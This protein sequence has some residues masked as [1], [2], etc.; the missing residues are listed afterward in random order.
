M[1]QVRREENGEANG[2]ATVS[3]AFFV[4]QKMTRDLLG[5]SGQTTMCIFLSEISSNFCIIYISAYIHIYIYIHTHMLRNIN[6][7]VMFLDA[8][9]NPVLYSSGDC[10]FRRSPFSIIS[11]FIS[12]TFPE[13]LEGLVHLED[14]LVDRRKREDGLGLPRAEEETRTG[15]EL[16]P[17]TVARGRSSAGGRDKAKLTPEQGGVDS[18]QE[19]SPRRS[20][21]H[22]MLF[23]VLSTTPMGVKTT[24]VWKSNRLAAQE[25][26]E[27]EA[28]KVERESEKE[29]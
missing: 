14:P 19:R 27:K 24:S 4:V 20:N 29:N 21:I 22:K 8:V 10:T 18:S 25:E 9:A 26:R 16:D 1:A 12:T 7:Y 17:S 11:R 6:I 13:K 3:I 2:T 5:G 23:A 15:D 28:E